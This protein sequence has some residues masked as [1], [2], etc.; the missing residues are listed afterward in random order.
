[1][2][3]TNNTLAVSENIKSAIL[4]EMNDDDSTSK[5]TQCEKSI[6]SQLVSVLPDLHVFT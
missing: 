1:M 6:I 2:V 4:L 5:V 3:F